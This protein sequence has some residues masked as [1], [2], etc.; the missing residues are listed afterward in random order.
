MMLFDAV[1]RATGI[2]ATS[3]PNNVERVVHARRDPL[4][5]YAEDGLAARE[6]WC[7]V[8]PRLAEHGFF[9]AQPGRLE[10]GLS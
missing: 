3:I 6:V 10:S 5:T 4:I 9:G 1:D 2:D 7:W 8:D